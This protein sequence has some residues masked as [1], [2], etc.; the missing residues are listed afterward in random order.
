MLKPMMR[1]AVL[2][3]AMI[4]TR[5]NAFTTYITEVVTRTIV[6]GDNIGRMILQNRF[7]ELAPSTKAA[8]RTSPG[9]LLSAAEKTT[10]AKPVEVQMAVTISA[11]LTRSW[12]PSH[13]TGLKPGIRAAKIAL[14]TPV[15]GSL[16]Y[17]KRQMM[18]VAVNEMPIGT[19]MID[20]MMSS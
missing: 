16:L 2:S 12:R 19:K 14:I 17:T 13:A 6:V 7:H 15:L 10:I 18:P 20:L 8:S 5:S 4:Y 11:R 3:W 1:A 9:R